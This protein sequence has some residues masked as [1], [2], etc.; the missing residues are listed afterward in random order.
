MTDLEKIEALTDL[1]SDVIHALEMTQYDI[2]NPTLSYNS[3]LKA[4]SYHDQ[5]LKILHGEPDDEVSQ[6]S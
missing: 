4:D 3:V 6:D 2:E 5:M 1:L